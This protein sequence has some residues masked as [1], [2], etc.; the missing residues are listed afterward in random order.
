MLLGFD[1]YE[2]FFLGSFCLFLMSKCLLNA[3]IFYNK[4]MLSR[5][6]F[7]ISSKLNTLTKNN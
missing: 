1:C 6:L 5:V 4:V 3:F 7:N 2:V